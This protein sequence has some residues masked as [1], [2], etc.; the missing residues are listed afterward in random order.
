MNI[1]G[2]IYQSSCGHTRQYAELLSEQLKLPAFDLFAALRGLQRY[3][4]VIFIGWVRNRDLMGYGL[5]L[6][7]YTVKAVCAVGAVSPEVSGFVLDRIE[8]RY[9]IRKNAPLFYLQGGFNFKAVRGTDRRI[10]D[11]MKNDLA[12]KVMR[13][14]KS[15]KPI[16][17]YDEALF[18]ALNQEED[19]VCEENL[20]ELINWYQKT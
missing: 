6:K 17:P 20:K 5:M 7:R 13:R 19:Y 2:I 18:R 15:G 14:R 9:H 4:E 11:A 16:A 1:K 8:R 12:K 10:A 3:D